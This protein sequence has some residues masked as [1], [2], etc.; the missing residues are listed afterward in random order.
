MIGEPFPNEP[1]NREIGKSKFPQANSPFLFASAT[2]KAKS[3]L[4]L[5]IDVNNE[6]GLSLSLSLF[7]D[8]LARFLTG[9]ASDPSKIISFSTSPSAD[10]RDRLLGPL[11]LRFGFGISF[12]GGVGSFS[13]AAR[14]SANEFLR[15][16]ELVSFGGVG[17]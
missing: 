6:S 15:L 9:C 12:G 11:D 13:R 5:V 1:R 10:A 8:L 17:V 7:C 16:S 3:P 14:R 2:F 4:H